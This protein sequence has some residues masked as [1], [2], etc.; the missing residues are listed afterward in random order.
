[1][2][3][4]TNRRASRCDDGPTR[5]PSTRATG[6]SCPKPGA[7]T[8]IAATPSVFLMPCDFAQHRPQHRRRC[9]R[10]AG[11]VR[12][13]SQMR[14]DHRRM[15]EVIFRD[16]I[17]TRTLAVE[18]HRRFNSLRAAHYDGS[19]LR[20]PG[21]SDHFTPHFYQPNAVA[22]IVA[23]PSTPLDRV[24]YAGKT[25]T[26][27]V[28]AQTRSGAPTVD[29]KKARAAT[30]TNC[31]AQLLPNAPRTSRSN[32]ESCVSAAWKHTPG[33]GVPCPGLDFCWGPHYLPPCGNHRAVKCST[34]SKA[35]SLPDTAN[36][37]STNVSR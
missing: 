6:G 5:S 21:L 33:R 10:F 22:R 28:A 30:L 27:L 23:E 8:A 29:N 18:Y 17:R 1:M 4:T 13:A 16:T 15:S 14:E 11:H 25:G 19:K 35:A 36:A 12:R 24:V 26:M 3:W 37:N 34:H 31:P 20:L 9:A 7:L 2:A 32:Y